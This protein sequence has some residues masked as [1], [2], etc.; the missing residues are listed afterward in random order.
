MYNTSWDS[1][2]ITQHATFIYW[3]QGLPYKVQTCSPALYV[4]AQKQ[5]AGLPA[6]QA[7]ERDTV[8]KAPADCISYWPLDFMVGSDLKIREKEEDMLLKLYSTCNSNLL[9][10][11][12]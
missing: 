1:L 12:P 11:L 7:M 6:E 9:T 5:M 2:V 8:G 10:P 3:W 4:Y